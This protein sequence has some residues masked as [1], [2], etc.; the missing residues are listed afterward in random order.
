MK[1]TLSIGYR[2]EQAATEYLR[3]H[4][5]RIL[6]RNWRAGRYEL[7]IVARKKDTLHFVEVKSRKKGSL[8]TPE[9]AL[10]PSKFNALCHA[11]RAWLA[12]HPCNLEINFDLAAVDLTPEGCTV[13][14]IPNAVT[15][16]W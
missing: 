13:R 6:D 11:A 2:G 5:F 12:S 10:T 16:H 15:P 7:D 3:A 14:Y 4:G 1:D 9:E 8:T